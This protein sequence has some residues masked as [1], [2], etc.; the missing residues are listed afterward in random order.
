MKQIKTHKMSYL[1]VSE[2]LI[3]EGYSNKI[4][5]KGS[6]LNG[7]HTI[8][9]GMITAQEFINIKS[10]YLSIYFTKQ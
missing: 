8:R 9:L 4:V 5:V 3:K 7:L 10:K 1:K 2:E 6:G